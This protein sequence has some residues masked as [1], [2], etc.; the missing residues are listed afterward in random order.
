M[1]ILWDSPATE[2][3]TTTWQQLTVSGDIQ[4]KWHIRLDAATGSL[5]VGVRV[6]ARVCACV[7]VFDALFEKF[8]TL[9]SAGTG[10]RPSEVEKETKKK[11][12]EIRGSSR[13]LR[14]W[15]HPLDSV[16]KQT[17]VRGYN[18]K[19]RQRTSTLCR[20]LVQSP[21]ASSSPH[22]RYRIAISQV[23][24]WFTQSLQVQEKRHQSK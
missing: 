17:N 22:S 24:V 8:V 4:S 23:P 21:P 12:R 19:P 16:T 20:Q 13:C 7:H 5:C 9:A 18:N 1:V 11:L 2:K 3:T 14:Y 15:N 6:R 10:T